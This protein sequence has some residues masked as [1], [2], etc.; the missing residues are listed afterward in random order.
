MEDESIPFKYNSTKSREY[1]DL[2]A[3]QQDLAW[4][5][6]MADRL[7]TETDPTI[8]RA[9][10]TAALIG[11][12][13][14]FKDGVRARMNRSELSIFDGGLEYHDFWISMAD[15]FA[16]H[17]VNP[18]EQIHV[19]V[20]VFDSQ[21]RNVVTLSA[22]RQSETADSAKDFAEFIRNILRS[23]V[24]PKINLLADELIAEAKAAPISQIMRAEKLKLVIPHPAQASAVRSRE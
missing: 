16:A 22:T 9:L 5:G 15:K 23:I 12:R 13:R 19:G 8:K 17:S 7:A 1:A 21:V 4:V 20:A 10:Y 18:F 24:T 3:V 11:Y 14:C 2:L 6:K